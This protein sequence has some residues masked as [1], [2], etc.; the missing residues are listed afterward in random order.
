MT[1]SATTAETTYQLGPKD[2]L[3]LTMTK[4]QLNMRG[5]IKKVSKMIVVIN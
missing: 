2:W 1:V 4:R 3:T 5:K